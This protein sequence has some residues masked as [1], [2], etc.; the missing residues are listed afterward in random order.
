MN[1]DSTL[2]Y[3]FQSLSLLGNNYRLRDVTLSECI[4]ITDLGLEKF[5]QQCKEIERLDLSHC[6][7]SLQR[8]ILCHI[9]S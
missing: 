3:F 4:D 7:V 9:Y 2:L 6:W 1:F 8:T 5:T